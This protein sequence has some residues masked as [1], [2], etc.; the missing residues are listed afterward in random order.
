MDI[1]PNQ[2]PYQHDATDFMKPIRRHTFYPSSA[3]TKPTLLN[4][5]SRPSSPTK[6]SYA[7]VVILYLYPL[8]FPHPPDQT[9]YTPT[10]YHSQYSFLLFYILCSTLVLHYMCYVPLILNSPTSTHILYLMWFW[11]ASSLICGNK[12]PT[13]YTKYHRQQSLYKTIQL[14]MIDIVMPETC[15]ASNKISNKNLCCI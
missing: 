6:T 15:W 3:V 8:P 7:Q 9:V 5:G 1:V 14:P 10:S 2:S 13:K 12:I 4:T 11:L